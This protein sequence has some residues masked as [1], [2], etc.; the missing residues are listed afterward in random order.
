MSNLAAIMAHARFSPNDPIP[1]LRRPRFEMFEG[2]PAI[3]PAPGLKHQAAAL[4]IAAALLRH[5]EDRKLGWIVQAPCDL[6]LSERIVMQPD[7]VFVSRERKGILREMNLRGT[8]DLVVEVLSR[9]THGKDLKTRRK[10]YARSE[11]PEYWIVEPD[12]RTIET[13]IRSEL[14]FVSLGKFGKSDR[15]STPLLPSLNLR[16]AGI[17][18]E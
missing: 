13:L 5:V 14:G 7:V 6:I 16:L 2:A 10:I 11:V 15:L 18:G 17:F 9:A 1:I 4:K 3:V 12:D 8:P